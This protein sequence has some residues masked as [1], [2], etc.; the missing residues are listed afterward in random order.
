MALDTG[1]RRPTP[2][3]DH[4]PNHIF[5]PKGGISTALR[6]SLDPHAVLLSSRSIGLCQITDLLL[7]TQ[8]SFYFVYNLH[9]V[10]VK[11]K[12]L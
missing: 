9:E 12:W 7:P 5:K 11:G 3:S 4:Q 8:N 1:G 10:V 2:C 6:A